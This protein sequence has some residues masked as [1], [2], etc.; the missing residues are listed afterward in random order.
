MHVHSPAT[1]TGVPG[2]VVGVGQNMVEV[3]VDGQLSFTVVAV[4]IN[5]SHAVHVNTIIIHYTHSVILR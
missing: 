5:N 3:N 2:I 1:V 4:Y